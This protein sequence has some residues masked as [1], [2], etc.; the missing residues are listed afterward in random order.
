MYFECHN[1]LCQ[2]YNDQLIYRNDQVSIL[3]GGHSFHSECLMK[4]EQVHYLQEPQK[5]DIMEP[6]KCPAICCNPIYHW[7]GEKWNYKYID[8]KVFDKNS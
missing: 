3:K 7:K 5:R 4:Y 2:T 1:C 6:Y 8:N